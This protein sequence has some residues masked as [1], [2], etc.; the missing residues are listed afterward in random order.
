M[1]TY[2]NADVN[3]IVQIE[4]QFEYQCHRSLTPVSFKTKHSY[5]PSYFR[6]VS[7]Q[8]ILFIKNLKSI[9]ICI[10]EFFIDMC[11][12]TVPYVDKFSF[13]FNVAN[14]H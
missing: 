7:A 14:N 9:P 12:I 10:V 4:H 8:L 2:I 5:V 11:I 6:S 3:K 13:G 1:Q